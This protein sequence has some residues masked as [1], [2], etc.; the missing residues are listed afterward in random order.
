MRCGAPK[1]T[2]LPSSPATEARQQS[3]VAQAWTH[4]MKR[5]YWQQLNPVTPS[6]G[7]KIFSP[8][9]VS[10][11]LPQSIRAIAIGPSPLKKKLESSKVA[12][13]FPG[14]SENTT[15]IVSEGTRISKIPSPVMSVTVYRRI[16]DYHGSGQQVKTTRL[17]VLCKCRFHHSTHQRRL[18]RDSYHHLD[19]SRIALAMQGRL[20]E[21]STS[22][23]KMCHHRGRSEQPIDEP[24]PGRAFNSQYISNSIIVH[25][26]NRQSEWTGGCIESSLRSKSSVTTS[27]QHRDI[28]R[29]V[30]CNC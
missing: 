5:R 27:Q 13:P 26:T 22:E 2:N 1:P 28:T 21:I 14:K 9:S 30:V 15:G 12:S 29:I 8:S 16:V 19:H 20:Q 7:P 10:I 23:G 25:I 17:P 24:I 18:N 3:R 6:G 11:S 4:S